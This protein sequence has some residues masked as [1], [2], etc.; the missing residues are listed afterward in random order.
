MALSKRCGTSFARTE[1]FKRVS[2]HGQTYSVKG[3]TT[4]T[5]NDVSVDETQIVGGDYMGRSIN[6]L[7]NFTTGNGK[8][9]SGRD[10]TNKASRQNPVN[11]TKHTR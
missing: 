11:T 3:L 5:M 10:I 8:Q 4:K 1:T 6:R 9:G 7:G 2:N